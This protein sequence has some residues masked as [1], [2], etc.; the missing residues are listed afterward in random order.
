MNRRVRLRVAAKSWMAVSA[1]HRKAAAAARPPAKLTGRIN[2]TGRTNVT[3]RR[4][5]VMP[6]R[7]GGLTGMKKTGRHG[8]G[9]AK[10]G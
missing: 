9:R 8:E 2:R 4:R 1:I 10:T 3:R 6:N 7:D 5:A